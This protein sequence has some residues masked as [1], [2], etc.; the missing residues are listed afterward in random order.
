MMPSQQKINFH[1]RPPVLK[2]GI[3]DKSAIAAQFK[4]FDDTSHKDEEHWAVEIRSI[5]DARLLLRTLDL[6]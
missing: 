3:Y 6:Q 2:V 4:S 5:D 1:F